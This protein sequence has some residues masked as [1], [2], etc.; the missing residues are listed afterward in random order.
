MAE[1]PQ[2]AEPPEPWFRPEPRQAAALAAE[3][4][5]EIGADHELAGHRLTAVVKCAGCDEVIFRVD[6]GTFAKVHLTWARHPEPEPWPAAQRLGG[7]LAL[8]TAIDNHQH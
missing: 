4:Q 5:A 6:D 8:E 1:T 7:F 2:L 3:A